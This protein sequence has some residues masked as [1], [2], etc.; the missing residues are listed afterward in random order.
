MIYLDYAATHP[1]YM[2]MAREIAQVINKYFYNPS[3]LYKPS[4]ETKNFYEKQRSI[5][6]D[7]IGVYKENLIFLSSATEASN[8][9]IKGLNYKGRNKVILWEGEHPAVYEPLINMSDIKRETI[10]T[11][12]G[13]VEFSDIEQF[14]DGNVK[15]ICLMHVNNETGALNDITNISKKIKEID[16]DILIFSDTTQ[17][18]AKRPIDLTNIDFA[19]FSSHKIGGLRGIAAMYIK[20]KNLI[21]PLLE[22]GGQEMG[23][24]S[25][26]ENVYAAYTMAKAAKLTYNIFND[27][28]NHLQSL[29]N[30]LRDN[31]RLRNF[32]INSPDCSVYNIFNFS[33]MNLPSEVLINALSDM[34]IYVSSGSACSSKTKGSRTLRSMDFN[35]DII[36]TSIRVSLHPTTTIRDLEILF[37]SIDKVVNTFII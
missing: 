20:N 30:F 2:S 26:T 24:R 5:L 29:N 27:K 15:L 25:G 18:F 14:I 37:E 8:T 36:D 4:I 28:N 3:S 34:E 7:V 12:K 19:C 13:Y 9:I 17:S 10:K 31:C 32:N 35:S 1:V 16:K 22:G 21:K 6:A 11:K 33:T 23:L